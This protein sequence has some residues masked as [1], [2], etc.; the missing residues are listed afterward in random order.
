[1]T[2]EALARML[3]QARTLRAGFAVTARSRG[4]AP[5]PQPSW[6]SSSVTSP[7]ASADGTAWT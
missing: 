5:R 4:T 7:S 2:G 6:P 3:S 1:M